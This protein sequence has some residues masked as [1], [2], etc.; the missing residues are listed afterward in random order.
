MRLKSVL[1]IYFLALP[2]AVNNQ[3]VVLYIGWV[4]D[5]KV[6][7]CI[8]TITLLH[9]SPYIILTNSCAVK[10]N[11][12]LIGKPIKHIINNTYRYEIAKASKLLFKADNAGIIKFDATPLANILGNNIKK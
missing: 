10:P 12:K 7:Y 4:K 3:P 11:H 5:A 8:K 9:P 6:R 1:Y 2:D